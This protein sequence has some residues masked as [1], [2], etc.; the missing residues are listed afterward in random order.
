M[1]VPS[2]WAVVPRLARVCPCG[3]SLGADVGEARGLT[4]T[5]LDPAVYMRELL[6]D[7]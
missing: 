1:N 5:I 4:C 3:P 7:V 6:H 2:T